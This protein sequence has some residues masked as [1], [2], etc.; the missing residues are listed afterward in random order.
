MSQNSLVSVLMPVKNAAPFLEACVQSILA[1]THTR[2][3]LL[4]VDDGSTDE[5]LQ[6]LKQWATTDARISVLTNTGA[7]IID[8]L[9]LAYSRS[10]GM[11]ITRMDADDRMAPI[12]LE[13]LVKK[14]TQHGP[15]HLAT[16]CVQYFSNAELGEGYRNYEAW[17]NGL[18]AQGS[19]FTDIYRECVIPSP[20]WMVYR[21]DLDRCVAF[22]PSVYPEDYDL[23]FRFYQQKL[24]VIPCKEVLHHWR[25]HAS[26]TSRNHPNYADNRFLELKLHWFL[27]LDHDPTRT[28]VL[29]GAGQKGK[30]L[31]RMLIQQDVPFCWVCNNPKK[32]GKDIFGITMQS[33]ED[34]P[35][36]EN[37]QYIVAV[38]EPAQREAIRSKTGT[39]GFFFC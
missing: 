23:C 7:G 35:C 31:A 39:S 17:L 4:A 25:D 15:G 30:A 16:G 2:W 27:Q 3:E 1:Q 19:N 18:T 32:I 33:V 10:K 28:L 21:T 36:N 6:L 13:T 14:L 11:L 5:S 20:C 38:A 29:W 22:E 34:F 8:A 37:E 24:T 9:R 12:K 26:R